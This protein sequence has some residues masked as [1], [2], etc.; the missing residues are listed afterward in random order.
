MNATGTTA[1]CWLRDATF[2]LLAL[3]AVGLTGE[4]R[5]WINWLQRAV[6]GDPIDLQP[7]YSVTGEPRALEWEAGWLAGFEGSTP[8]RFGNGAQGQLQL[9]IFGEVIDCLYQARKHGLADGGESDQLVRMIAGKLAEVWEQ[10]DAGIW[11][12]RGEPRQH[13]YS[14]VMCWV[15][16][17]RAAAWFEDDD[18]QL[19]RTYRELA[20]KAH[21][22]VCEKGWSKERG[23]FVR[24]FDDPALDAAL[25]RLPLVGFLP[26]DDPRMTA[27]IAAIE[28]EL[29][30]E[31]LVRRYDPGATDD[32]LSGSEGAFVAAGFWLAEAMHSAGRVDEARASFERLLGRANDLGLLAEELEIGGDRQLGNF[33]QALSHLALVHSLAFR[34]DGGEAMDPE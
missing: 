23:C 3:I 14:K 27:T 4:A 20:D 12:S 16:F 30:E 18:A 33:P 32:G 2:T 34:L 11:E 15:A 10:P 21:A 8:V 31:G 1:I 19:S 26:A 17:D 6:G 28:H 22:L 24:A 9:D 13:T 5:A 25:L 29:C 7:F